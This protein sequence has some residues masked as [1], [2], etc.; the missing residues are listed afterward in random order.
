M[1]FEFSI[2]EQRGLDQESETVTVIFIDFFTGKQLLEAL[3]NWL[4]NMELMMT[5]L[6]RFSLGMW[7]INTRF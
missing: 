1:V 2:A 5:C 7:Q 6:P 3:D 4:R